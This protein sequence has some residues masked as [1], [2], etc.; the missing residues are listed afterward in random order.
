MGVRQFGPYQCH[1]I[2]ADT[3]I[4]DMFVCASVCVYGWLMAEYYVSLS[5]TGCIPSV[6]S[7]ENIFISICRDPRAATIGALDRC[8]RTINELLE[9]C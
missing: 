3:R 1:S 6:V 8:H 2:C 7:G 9:L 5:T 4:G